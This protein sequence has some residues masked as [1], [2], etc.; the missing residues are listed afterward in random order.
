MV[1][2]EVFREKVANQYWGK[3]RG[4]YR[5]YLRWVE[6]VEMVNDG[7]LLG[8]VKYAAD[9]KISIYPKIRDPLF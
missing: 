1:W 6:S 5:Q 9:I 3:L 2:H 8:M 4:I 7:Y